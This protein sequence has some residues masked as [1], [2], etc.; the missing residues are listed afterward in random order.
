[1]LGGAV[2][3]DIFVSYRR[4]DSSDVTDRICDEMKRRLGKDRLFKDVDSIS[5]GQDFRT[6][7]GE[8][9]GQC[10]VLLAVIGKDWLTTLDKDGKRRLDDPDDYVHIEIATALTRGIP[11]IPVLVENAVL[12][13]PGDLPE[14]LRNLVFR[15]GTPVRSDPDFHHDMDRLCTQ[16]A[17]YIQKGSMTFSAWAERIK[18]PIFW[19][20][21]SGA[22]AACVGIAVLVGNPF[23]RPAVTPATSNAPVPI[24][25]WIEQLPEV[26]GADAEKLFSNALGSWQA[27]VVTPIRKADSA[28][29]ANVVVRKSSET[30]ADAQVGPPTSKTSPLIIRFGSTVSWTPRTFEAASNRM[31]GHILGLRYTRTPNQMMTEGIELDALPLTPQAEDIKRVRQIWDKE[32]R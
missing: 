5:L 27:V 3:R 1:M 28:A 31:L 6:A 18:T 32:T 25:Y 2:M 23:Q 17:K 10:K 7:I 16:L 9:V 29:N 30:I 22:A 4:T 19:A 11:V 14:P 13:R 21:T 24:R 20:W 8:A 15:N 26:P 12:P